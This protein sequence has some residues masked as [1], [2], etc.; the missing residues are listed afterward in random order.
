V[1]KTPATVK[2]V[3][4]PAVYQTQKVRKLVSAPQEKRIKVPA[5][6]ESITKRVKLHDAKLEW[7]RVLCETNMTKDLILQIQG[8]LQ[9]A[10]YNPGPVDGVIGRQTL[11]AVD[12]YQKK[13]S[14]P[15]GGLTMLTLEK[16]GI[17]VQ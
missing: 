6:K 9:K 4:I 5:Q 15:T 10:G 16:L 2:K 1:V 17:K 11:V 3:E 8:A 13:N 14:L 12:Q 7:R